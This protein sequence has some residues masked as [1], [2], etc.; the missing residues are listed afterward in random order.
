M[1]LNRNITLKCGVC[2]NTNFEYDDESYSSIEE[3]EQ[4]KCSVCNKIYTQEELKEANTTL[5]N[6]T[7]EE[8]AKEV[9][10]KELKKLGFKITGK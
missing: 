7:A 9:L 2:G 8:L 5:I 6:N 3:A 10:E 1:D 4:V